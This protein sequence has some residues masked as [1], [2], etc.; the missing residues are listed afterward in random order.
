MVCSLA[1]NTPPERQ[2]KAYR[3]IQLGPD[4]PVSYLMQN[5]II[6]FPRQLVLKCFADRGEVGDCRFRVQMEWRGVTGVL[7][8]PRLKSERIHSTNKPLHGEHPAAS[9]RAESNCS[10]ATTGG[11]QIFQLNS[12][13]LQYLTIGL[14]PLILN[15]PLQAKVPKQPTRYPRAN[16]G[17]VSLTTMPQYS[18]CGR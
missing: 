16:R 7:G 2:N 1:D 4:A 10:T 9:H 17:S 13:P 15:K 12:I 8:S 3:E 11:T 18:Q 6:G 14:E 5:L